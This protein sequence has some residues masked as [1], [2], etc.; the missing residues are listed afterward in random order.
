[1]PLLSARLNLMKLAPKFTGAAAVVVVGVTVMMTGSLINALA[2]KARTMVYIS[3]ADSREIYVL[4]LNQKD[5]SS[6]VVERVPVV[7]S[8]MPLAI[9]PDRKYLYAS[10]RSEPYAVSSF[11]INPQSGR[12]TL[13]KTVPLVDNMAYLATDRSGRYLLGA[14]Y[15]GHKISVNAISLSGE[16][17]PKPLEVVPTGKNAHA[18]ATDLSNRFLFVTNL[19][20]D[21]IL[22]YRFNQ[23]DGAIT[24]N[25]PPAVKTGT[26]AG[27]RHFVF[28]PDRRF[29]FGLNELDG[30]VNTY[31]LQDS[32]VL[33]LL[34]SISAMPAAFEGKPSAADI[35]LTPDGKFLYASERASNTIAAFR[36]NGRSGKLTLIG[37]YPTETQPR[38]FNIDPQGKYL[39]VAG[40]KSN[41]LSTYE[42]NRDTGA[43]RRLSRLDL[44][45]NPNWIEIIVLPE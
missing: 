11:A 37:N 38:G 15:L 22:Q 13:V 16:V 30:T 4:E 44:G 33:A 9:S 39:L 1:M 35:H 5:G 20:D 6:T 18:I 40:Q 21:M 26:G 7:G 43:L 42:I 23:A 41:G 25:E 12:L 34:D 8:V 10:L 32:G 36:I 3:N 27:P 31:R 28:H 45:Q 14:S 24:P 2:A 29:V 19:G 17:D